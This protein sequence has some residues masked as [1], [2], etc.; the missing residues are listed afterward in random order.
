MT[1]HIA[2]IGLGQTG[3]SVGLAL[4]DQK[5]KLHRT[6]HDIDP[7]Q[8]RQAEKQGAVDSIHFNLPAAVEKA[9]LVVL[10]LPIDQ[11]KP[12]L[13]VIAPVLRQDAVVVDFAPVKRAMLEWARQ[14]LPPDRHYVGLAPVRNPLYLDVPEADADTAHADFFHH[15]II[16]VVTPPGTPAEANRLAT[17]LIS[18]LGAE[19]LFI[20]PYELDGLV[21]ATHILPELLSSALVHATTAQ[22][23]WLEARKFADKAYAA[24]TRPAAHPGTAAAL[25]RMALNAPDNTLRVLDN[26]IDAL[27][28]L[29]TLVAEGDAPALEAYFEQARQ[30]RL[31][32]WEQRSA[33][34]WSKE[35]EPKVEPFGTGMILGRLLGINRPKRPKK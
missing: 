6:G 2:I 10:A 9:D 14:I 13:E 5:E 24:V 20:D 23:G 27:Q 29:R 11:I 34:N 18:L 12:T 17:D 7:A 8:A 35:G 22:P 31:T 3:A 15:S 26:A 28:T 32:W 25:T 19:H 16:A 33:G 4:A 1:V 21:A 30:N